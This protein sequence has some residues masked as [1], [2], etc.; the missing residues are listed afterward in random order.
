MIRHLNAKLCGLALIIVLV[1]TPAF[2][3]WTVTF[4]T[5]GYPISYDHSDG[6]QMHVLKIKCISDANAS[7][8]QTL[9]TLIATAY[10]GANKPAAVAMKNKI[11][12]GYF[13]CMKYSLA[14][15][16]T[17]PTFAVAD[18]VGT[19][20]NASAGGTTGGGSFRGNLV[21]DQ[22]VP[23][24]DLVFSSTTLGDTKIMYIYFWISK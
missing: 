16:S 4:E 21:T 11:A 17:A 1:A 19:S 9:S 18:E 24:T 5:T 22:Y 8:N 15:E 13:Y 12:G 10:G 6:S 14:Q 20:L 7:G 23:V 2:A 3:A